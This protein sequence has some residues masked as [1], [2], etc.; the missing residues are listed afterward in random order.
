MVAAPEV[1]ASGADGKGSGAVA[2]VGSGTERAG[3]GDDMIERE[4]ADTKVVGARVLPG[5][6]RRL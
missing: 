6:G 3:G 2:V 1:E 5:L 4:L